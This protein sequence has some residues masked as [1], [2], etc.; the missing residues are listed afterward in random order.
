MRLK[1]CPFCGKELDNYVGRALLESHDC[2]KSPA[3]ARADCCPMCGEEYSSWLDHL[4]NCR[5]E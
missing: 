3:S 2:Q 4:K 1:A 5:G